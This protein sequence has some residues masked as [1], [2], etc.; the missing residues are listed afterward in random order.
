MLESVK[1]EFFLY[2]LEQNFWKSNRAREQ[3]GRVV[4]RGR[5]RPRKRRGTFRGRHVALHRSQPPAG[6]ANIELC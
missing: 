1:A 6:E 3:E 4:K 2:Y 5:G